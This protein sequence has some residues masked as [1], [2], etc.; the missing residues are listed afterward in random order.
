VLD[1]TDCSLCRFTLDGWPSRARA[2]A[3][4][5]DS[6]KYRSSAERSRLAAKVE[7]RTR[8]VAGHDLMMS[9][10]QLVEMSR[11]GVEI[12]AHTVTHPILR[13]LPDDSARNE[14]AA[15][16]VQLETLTGRR[17]ALFAYPNGR[18]GRDYDQRH[19][20]MVEELGFDAAVSTDRGVA[21]ARSHRFGL[22]RFGPW[23]ESPSRLLLRMLREFFREEAPQ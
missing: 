3:T 15:G 9:T 13:E 6:V 7:E 18:F 21:R 8:H 16:R 12:G 19:M 10:Q 11:A 4:L 23:Q 5:I 17:V 22:P 20:R 2:A 14:I 1:L